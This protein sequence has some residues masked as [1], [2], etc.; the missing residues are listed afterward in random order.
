LV[1][2]NCRVKLVLFFPSLMYQ[3]N[4]TEVI[5]YKSVKCTSQP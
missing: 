3:T 1:Y 5:I 2:Y 4:G